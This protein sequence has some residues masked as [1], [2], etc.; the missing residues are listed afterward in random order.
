MPIS[1]LVIYSTRYE[2]ASYRIMAV[3][4]ANLGGAASHIV[5]AKVGHG[6]MRMTWCPTP[7]SDE[8][9]FASIKGGIDALPPGV[10][11]FLNSAEFYGQGLTTANLD[12]LARFFTKYPEYAERTFLS[13]KGGG[14]P[15]KLVSDGSRANSRRSVDAILKALRGTKRLDL[16][17]PARPD[18]NYTMEQYAKTLNEM[19]KEGKF[20][21]I[22]LSGVD[23]EA[24]RSAHKFMPVAAVEIQVSLQAYEWRI[25]DTIAACKE[26][27]IAVIAYS[28]LGRGQLAP[29]PK[30]H[31]SGDPRQPFARS[32][33]H[34]GGNLIDYLEII[35]NRKGITVAQLS[36][37]WVGALGDLVIP[38][39]GSSHVKR[40]LENL[41]AG[42]V[43]LSAEDLAE[44]AQFLDNYT[45]DG[46]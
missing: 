8:Q 7:V 13:V 45:A 46:W 19:V 30:A 43:E 28:P 24:V 5:V 12:L 23:A 21:Y 40:T 17:Q 25:R 3:K 20:D 44:I 33:E 15:G 41:K 1:W 9:A 39:P 6:L 34:I 38:I 36:I 4:T 10:K 32:K 2:E 22:G 42:D 26:L 27:G 16:F 14:K 35:A 31:Q 18:P 37:A 11:M 29:L